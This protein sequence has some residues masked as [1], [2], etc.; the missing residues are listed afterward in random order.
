MDDNV[1]AHRALM[2][3]EY[4]ESKDIQRMAWPANS[5][6]LNLIEHAWDALGRVI[7]MRQPPPRN[8]LEL[9][10]ALLEEWEGLPS[11]TSTSKLPY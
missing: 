6:D 3:D 9:K 10:I 4:L 7:A 1:R 8:I 11:T 2:F 5:P